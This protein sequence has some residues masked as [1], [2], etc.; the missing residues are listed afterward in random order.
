MDIRDAFRVLVSSRANEQ[1]PVDFSVSVP[2][3]SMRECS[4]VQM[5]GAGSFGQV[6]TCIY[7]N[8][9]YVLKQMHV[10]V[11]RMMGPSLYQKELRLLESLKGHPNVVGI[12]GYCYNERA[13][14]LDYHRFS[15]QCLEIDCRPVSSL[16][17]LLILCHEYTHFV[18]CKHLQVNIAVDVAS[19]LQYLHSKDI[20]HRD[21][22]SENILVCN[23]HYTDDNAEYG[24]DRVWPYRP[25][26]CKLTDFGESRS[27]TVRTRI[28]ATATR[29]RNVARGSLVYRA[30]ESFKQ[31]GR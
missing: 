24:C 13:F 25:V 22:K 30:P 5:L 11:E 16:D 4:Q 10:D 27:S 1:R 28:N 6:F 21:L 3:F 19:G 31:V 23:R 8:E 15:F 26:V 12:R 17:R 7:G 9:K 29:T 20:V 14:M 18:G 2:T